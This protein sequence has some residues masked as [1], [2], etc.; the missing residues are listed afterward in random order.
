VPG[1]TTTRN[2]VLLAWAL[3]WAITSVDAR[4][5]AEPGARHVGNHDANARAEGCLKIGTDAVSV[6]A[7]AGG[8]DGVSTISGSPPAPGTAT[9]GRPEGGHEPAR[10]RGWLNNRSGIQYRPRPGPRTVRLMM[11]PSGLRSRG[12]RCDLANPYRRSGGLRYQPRLLEKIIPC[13]CDHGERV[14]SGQPGGLRRKPPGQRY[15][16]LRARGPVATPEETS[17][18]SPVLDADLQDW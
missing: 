17:K 7:S 5:V 14:P 3:L 4:G 13:I 11:K 2:S 9:P 8:R 10:D 12:H 18:W 6:S 15:A 1:R 16:A